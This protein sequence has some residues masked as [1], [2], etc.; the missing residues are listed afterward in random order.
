MRKDVNSINKLTKDF[1]ATLERLQKCELVVTEL[2]KLGKEWVPGS[3]PD[4]DSKFRELIDALN[5]IQAELEEHS[6]FEEKEIM[7]VLYKHAGEIISTGLILEH[8]KIL[9]SIARLKKS[10][11]ALCGKVDDRDERISLEVDIRGAIGGILELMQR[12]CDTQYIIYDLAKEV[13]PNKKAQGSK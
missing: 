11:Q 8:Q 7:P 5:A 10:A 13:L 3:P 4:L 6:T 1:R 12:H 2:T 9:N